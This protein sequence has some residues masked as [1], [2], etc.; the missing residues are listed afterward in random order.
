MRN[1]YILIFTLVIVVIGVTWLYFKNITPDVQNSERIFAITPNQTPLIFEFKNDES[2]Y[3]IFKDFEL[4]GNT[5]G[6]DNFSK[7][8]ALKAV[9][10][11]NKEV[12][13]FLSDRNIFI[14]LHATNPDETDFLL[15]TVLKNNFSN[16][17]T[18]K[19]IIA[20]I[21]KKYKLQEFEI[22]GATCY[23]IQFNKGLVFTIYFTNR[24][25]LGS[26]SLDLVKRCIQKSQQATTIQSTW[27]IENMKKNAN[28]IANI[29]IN[30]AALGTYLNNFS[31]KLE[32]PQLAGLKTLIASS[33]LNMNF[34]NEA[35]MFS[36][37]TT[38]DGSSKQFLNLFLNQEPQTITLKNLVPE[39]TSSYLIY[40]LSNRQKFEQDL[41]QLFRSRNE[42]KR[43]SRQIKN[44]AQK[45]GINLENE[46]KN[47]NW[48]KEFGVFTLASGDKI[49]IIKTGKSQKLN[50][51][52]STISSLVDDRIYRFSDSNL[53][54]YYFGDP[55]KPFS[56]PYF[57]FIENHVII[58]TN[59]SVIN[60]FI[61][62]YNRQ[63]LLSQTPRFRNFQ[64]FIANQANISFFIHNKN[65]RYL[66]GSFLSKK[67][68]EAY[69]S[70]DF[71]LKDFYALSLQLSADNQ[72][73]Y[74]N[75]YMNKLPLDLPDEL[76][77]DSLTIDTL[78]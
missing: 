65:S 64:Q 17:K 42:Q 26:F 7:I 41:Q 29:Y 45:H 71:G 55:M 75:L 32:E 36:G 3:D 53:L 11:D 20:N 9:F 63:N 46:L 52:L 14:S 44:I 21:R 6:R 68:N 66:I 67:A 57:A 50:F 1:F 59:T 5:I 38:A 13:N 27:K 19:Q 28:S 24:L 33:V 72:K 61:N 35:F 69:K 70:D 54:Y 43:L 18:Q 30:Y 2:V 22:N 15:Y 25:V 74:T 76:E 10:L 16:A 37:N 56:R 40:A 31:R 8:K 48:G 4:F 51:V 34:K 47:N 49:G 12:N 23:K 60:R 58:A 73:F 62:N 77:S 39:E 78:N